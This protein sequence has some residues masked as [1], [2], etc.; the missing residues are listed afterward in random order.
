MRFFNSRRSTRLGAPSTLL[1]VE[2]LDDRV[3]PSVGV[4]LA[5][6]MPTG[7][8]PGSEVQI[9]H[10]GGSHV[11]TNMKMIVVDAVAIDV[12]GDTLSNAGSKPGGAGDGHVDPFGGLSGGVVNDVGVIAMITRSSG[13]EIPQ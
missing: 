9:S 10:V 3:M 8:P 6:S 2:K 4:S 5:C 12:L 7:I 13:E 11:D 1:R